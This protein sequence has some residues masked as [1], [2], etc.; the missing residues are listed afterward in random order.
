MNKKPCSKCGTIKPLSDYS[1]DK[2]A[3]DGH[4][5]ACKECEK[6]RRAK[7]EAQNGD[8]IKAASK[9]YIETHK[10]E[11]RKRNQRHYQENH[12]YHIQ[13]KRKY[14]KEKRK[15]IAQHKQKYYVQNREREL[16][17]CKKWAKE[18]PEK[19]A[20]KTMKR[21]AIKKSRTI[22]CVDYTKILERDGYVCH[23]C[24]GN[25]PPEELHFDHIIPLSRGGVHSEEN[26]AVSHAVCNM[27]KS[28]K[29]LDEYLMLIS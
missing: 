11:I 5:A 4:F 29:T 1:R 2:K 15:Q 6:I 16:A 19:A 23:I 13:R 28:N 18:N 14:N 7:W 12:D 8:K 10:E 24:G 26:I 20:Q 27:R 25:V 17:R 3:K 9:V 22:G 21:A